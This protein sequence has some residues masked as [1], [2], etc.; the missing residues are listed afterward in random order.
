MAK[1]EF[2]LDI[3]SLR[4]SARQKM[5]QGPVTDSYTLNVNHVIDLLSTSMATEYLC[6]LRYRNHA[7]RAKALGSHKA[8]EE[9]LEHSN[10]EQEHADKLADRIV[11][12][13]GDPNMDP[14]AMAKKSHT[15]YKPCDNVLTMIEENLFAE[16]VAVEIYREL[17]KYFG[18]H[19]PVTRKLLEEILA[20]EEEHTDDLL[21]LKAEISF[22]K[23]GE[24]PK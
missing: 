20:T 3:E 23:Q 21:D 16:R 10:E 18:N 17:I 12:L 19:D 11:Q 24:L 8:A 6:F 22:M 4:Q 7:F 14:V 1:T 15:E 13:G 2:T 5:E 9:F